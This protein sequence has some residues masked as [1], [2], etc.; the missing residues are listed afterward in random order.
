MKTIAPNIAM[1]IEKPIAFATLNTRERN[2][3]SGM[4]G[5]AARVSHQRKT[6]TSTTP[7]RASP[8]I[9]GR[10]PRV[11]GAAPRGEQ[12]QRADAAAEQHR[13]EHVDAVTDVRR[14]QMQPR[15]DDQHGQR[16]DRQVHVEDPAPGEV[17]DEEAAE[18]R[19]GDRRDGEHRSDQAHVAPALSRR[20]DVRDDRLRADHQPAC[21]DALQR[22]E[23]DQLSHRSGR[24]RR[25]SSRRGR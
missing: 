20:D 19:P 14:V 18:Q 15:H 2:S 13:T 6:P 4:I 9:V 11:L 10:A 16:A 8:M 1:P 24:D 22:A 7:S 23:A 17:V 3:D 5:S 25:A 21:A 12:R